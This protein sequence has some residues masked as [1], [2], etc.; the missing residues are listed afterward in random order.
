V[1]AQQAAAPIVVYLVRH[2]ERAEDGTN[3]PPISTA[4]EARAQLVADMLRD[5]GVTHIHVT[6]F[7]RTRSTAA[8]AAAAA[9]LVPTVYSPEELDALA[10]R[11]RATAGRHLVVGHSNTVPELVAVLGGDPH[12]EIATDEYDRFYVLTLTAS[13]TSTVLL[14]FGAPYRP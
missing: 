1:W 8:P 4:G 6:D 10:V 11:L 14:R 7:R 2:A 12:G 9:S 5:A 3:D 13:G